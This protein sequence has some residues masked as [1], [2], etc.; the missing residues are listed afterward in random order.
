[1]TLRRTLWALPLT[2]SV[3]VLAHVVAFG[4]AHAPGAG[5]STA[6]FGALGVL[7]GIALLGTFANGLL[8]GSPGPIATERRYGYAPLLLA[9]AGLATFGLIELSEG[10]FGFTPLLQAA[11]AAIP[12]AYVLAAAARSTR[13]AIHEAGVLCARYASRDERRAVISNADLLRDDRRLS[14]IAAFVRGV[15]RGRA[16]P[17][18]I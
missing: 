3:A 14:V 7:L 10:H 4:F 17:I 1:M 9:A 8:G 5:H 12:L 13:R 6:L 15:S 16:P 2:V 11:L 18:P